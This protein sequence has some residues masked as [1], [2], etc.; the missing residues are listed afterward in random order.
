[1]DKTQE[2]HLRGLARVGGDLDI[3]QSLEKHLP[4]TMDRAPGQLPGHLGRGITLFGG[5][6]RIGRRPGLGAGCGV[7]ALHQPAEELRGIDA[8]LVSL[9]ELVQSRSRVPREHE[10][11]QA[12]DPAAVCEAQH[13]ADL[14]YRDRSRAMSDGLVED[15]KAVTS[16]AF[17]RLRN[18][19]KRFRLDFDTFRPR[20]F[21]EVRGELLGRNAA[22]VETLA[23]RQH[24]DWHL[25]HFGGRE[26]EFHMLGWFL[27]SLE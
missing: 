20:H 24:R 21:R 13:V 3:L 22:Q 25:I 26:Q 1:M 12:S 16:G 18:H 6:Q 8:E 27:K 23:S 11:Q 2:R 9:V 14:S 4:Q 7:K 15:R 10:L 19:S 17:G 5:L